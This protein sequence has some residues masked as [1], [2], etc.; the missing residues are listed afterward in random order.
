[1]RVKANVLVIA[2]VAA[3]ACTAEALIS[4][5]SNGPIADVSYA[6]YQGYYNSTYDLNV[7]K[8]LAMEWC[9]S[10]SNT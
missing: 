6:I 4:H 5:G 2:A 7:W 3:A 1:M 8:R 9:T 10:I